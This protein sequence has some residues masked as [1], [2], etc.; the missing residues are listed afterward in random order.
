MIG[1]SQDG[2]LLQK[3]I[4]YYNIQ[5]HPFILWIVPFLITLVLTGVLLYRQASIDDHE[6]TPKHTTPSWDDIW[7]DVNLPV[8]ALCMLFIYFFAAGK[9]SIYYS[10]GFILL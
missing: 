4:K 1:S 5:I 3:W 9:N 2:S 7:N 6:T 8:F 10:N